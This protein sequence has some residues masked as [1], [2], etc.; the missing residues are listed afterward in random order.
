MTSLLSSLFEALLS[1]LFRKLPEFFNIQSS[2][3]WLRVRR[4]I[5]VISL[6]MEHVGFQ[7]DTVIGLAEGG[8]VVGSILAANLGIHL[9]TLNRIFTES[10]GRMKVLIKSNIHD[11]DLRGKK[12]LLVDSEIYTGLTIENAVQF[13]RS[14]HSPSEIKTAALLVMKESHFWPDFFFDT[15]QKKRFM[16]WV[17]SKVWKESYK[18]GIPRGV[19][20]L[21]ENQGM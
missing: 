7:P 5:E 18:T 17:Y 6:K 4:G 2:E 11:I 20:R 21:R 19:E 16:P 3:S 12:I 1:L 15:I 10:K 8:S 9:L 13:L 14:N